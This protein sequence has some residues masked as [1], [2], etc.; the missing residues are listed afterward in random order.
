MT[1]PAASDS[2][3]FA[4]SFPAIEEKLLSRLPGKL[5]RAGGWEQVLLVPSNELREHLLQR[6]ASRWKGVAV[7][8]SVQTLYDFA[9]RLLKHRGV[10]PR[11]LPPALTSAALSAAVRGVYAGG[12]GDFSAI[13]GTPGFLPAIARPWPTSKRGGS[14]GGV[15]SR[16]GKP[17]R[18]ATPGRRAGGPSGAGSRMPSSG[19]CTRWEG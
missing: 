15:S 6:L 16:S 1:D 17:Q 9:L 5:A 12:T 11:E 13:A 10:F 8:A 3:L 14:S 2:R 4:G 18:K 19:R 7:G